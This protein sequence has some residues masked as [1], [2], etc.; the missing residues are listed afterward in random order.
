MK[1]SNSLNLLK[2]FYYTFFSS[3]L[4]IITIYFPVEC[5]NPRGLH[6]L[7]VPIML[8]NDYAKQ[9]RFS[10]PKKTAYCLFLEKDRTF[11]LQEYEYQKKPFQT[12]EEL[13]ISWEI[14]SNRQVLRKGTTKDQPFRGAINAKEMN[15]NL[16]CFELAKGNFDIRFLITALKTPDPQIYRIKL[17]EDVEQQAKI[18]AWISYYLRMG[19]I[20]FFTVTTSIISL[21]FVSK[22]VE[23][24]FFKIKFSKKKC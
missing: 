6:V 20:T 12:L 16:G 2:Y 3:L 9:F 22:T 1:N 21:Y 14:E 11:P 5:L 17:D 4:L 7:R 18:V 23:F 8:T 19:L 24:I 13:E 10:I 15:R